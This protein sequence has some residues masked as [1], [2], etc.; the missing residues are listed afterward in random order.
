MI[1][2]FDV[3]GGKVVPSVHCQ[4]IPHLKVIKDEFP[5]DY[6]NVYAYIFYLTCPDGTMNP[7]IN[8]PENTRES[9][10]LSDLKPEFDLENKKILDAIVKCRKMYETPTLRIVVGAKKMLD[11][12]AEKLGESLTFGKNGN[13]S[14][15]RGIMKEI[16]GY[17]EDYLILE[18]KLKEEQ[19]KVRGNVK[20]RYDFQP[21]YIDS[22]AD[23]ENESE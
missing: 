22:K 16:R 3:I 2:L 4:F 15:M 19:S 1:N 23:T 14:D 9:I 13:A 11:E 12:M 17:T 5:A 21:G 7:Y 6:M 8:Q 10:I 18:N 20:L